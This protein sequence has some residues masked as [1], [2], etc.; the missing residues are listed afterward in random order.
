MKNSFLLFSIT[1]V[2]FFDSINTNFA[3]T[4]T[5]SEVDGSSNENYESVGP[6]SSTIVTNTLNVYPGE[7]LSL[8]YQ[9]IVGQIPEFYFGR[10][11]LV[12]IAEGEKWRVFVGIATDMIPGRYVII[13]NQPDLN[14]ERINFTVKPSQD[15]LSTQ[16]KVNRSSYSIL[17]RLQSRQKK[18]ASLFKLPD[19]PWANLT[20]ILPISYPAKGQ[21]SQ[22]FGELQITNDNS[23]ERLNYIQLSTNKPQPILSPTDAISLKITEQKGIYSVWLDHGMGLFSHISGLK[24]ITIEEQDKIVAGSMISNITSSKTTTPHTIQWRIL[25]NGVL[26]NPHSAVILK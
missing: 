17:N 20:P 26:V 5:E 8:T 7:I 24:N 22:N 13:V 21:W 23:L 1:L 2:I 3:Q 15:V 11:R 6:G 18:T 19:L 9:R 25:F 14:N 12:A 10:K 16:T 4:P